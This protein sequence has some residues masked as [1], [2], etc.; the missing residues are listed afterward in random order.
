MNFPAT[1][2]PPAWHWVAGILSFAVLL[3][4]VLRAPWRRLASTTQRNLLFGLAI[5]LALLWSM[6]AG[7]RPGLNLHLMGAMAAT[8]ALGP[9]FAV[10]SM[11]IALSA[12][13][14]NGGIEWGAW[15]INFVLMVIVPVG[16]ARL[17]QRAIEVTLP[18]HFFI[19]IFVLSFMGSALAVVLQGLVA[20]AAMVAAGA[21]PFEFL[22]SEYLP[23][24]ILLGFSEA[25]I[26]GAVITLLVVYRPE[27]VWAFDDKRYLVGK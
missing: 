21:Y 10:L 25:W 24:F 15:P 3:K 8:L 9:H 2:F 12:L 26:S 18:S 19:F 17:L 1:L 27:W 5:T 16:V 11:A 13:A 20:C 22:A 4:I 14:A 23:Y 7:V 6:K